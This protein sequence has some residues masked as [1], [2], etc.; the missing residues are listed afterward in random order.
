MTVRSPNWK[1]NYATRTTIYE[2]LEAWGMQPS[3]YTLA[4][5][6]GMTFDELVKKKDDPEVVRIMDALADRHGYA[7][8]QMLLAR[9]NAD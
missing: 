7:I 3:F 8:Y 1:R 6:L 2:K 9:K 5:L 4:K